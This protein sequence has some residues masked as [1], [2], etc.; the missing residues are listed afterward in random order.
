MSTESILALGLCVLSLALLVRLAPGAIRSWQI[1]SGTGRRH[2]EDAGDRAPVAPPNVEDRI[3]VLAASG[4]R[5]IGVTRLDLPVGER[6]AWIVAVDDGESYAMLVGGLT[7]V[8][9][10]AI[11]SAWPDG[12]WLSTMHPQGSSIDR[13]GLQI[14]VIP[15]SLDATVAEHRAGLARLRAVHGAPHQVRTLADMLACDLDYRA[16]FAGQSLRPITLRNMLPAILAA[17]TMIIA[18]ILLVLTW[19]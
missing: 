18:R 11:Y 12:S 1:Y 19:R 5:P 10:T 15:T 8:P 6:F 13:G 7:G 16:R 9:L 3:A 2:Q 14:R 17:G 4:Y